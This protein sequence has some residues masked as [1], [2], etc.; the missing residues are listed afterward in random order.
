ME[1]QRYTCLKEMIT[2][3]GELRCCTIWKLQTLNILTELMIVVMSCQ[4]SLQTTMDKKV[5]AEH[6]IDK[7]KVQWLDQGR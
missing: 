7:P 4:G 5:I 1:T 2:L 6:F 3:I